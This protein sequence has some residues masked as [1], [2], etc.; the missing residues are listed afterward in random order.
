MTILARADGN[1]ATARLKLAL[2][3]DGLDTSEFNK[4]EWAYLVSNRES[5]AFVISAVSQH[6]VSILPAMLTDQKAPLEHEIVIDYENNT[7][8]G[9]MEPP[10]TVT[11]LGFKSNE[12]T[13][14][15]FG[16]F[17]VAAEHWLGRNTIVESVE[18][19]TWPIFVLK[20]IEGRQVVM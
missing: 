9:G 19:D 6:A 5:R 13:K 14:N 2:H 12:A 3:R 7:E 20:Q 10:L 1:R 15:M 17:D 11:R 4:K 18:T 8:L 16:E